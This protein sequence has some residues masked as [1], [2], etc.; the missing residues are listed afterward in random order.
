M[1]VA[2]ID[3][4]TNSMRLLVLAEDG[5]EI[6]RRVEVTGL[7]TGVDAT[8]HFAEDRLRDTL[9]VMGEFGDAIRHLGAHNVAA[10][11]TSATRDA[12]NGA[13]LTGEVAELIGIVPEVIS[14]ER[15]AVLSFAGAT[16]GRQSG[17]YIVID[18][19]GGSTEFIL[20]SIGGESRTIESAVS[21]DLGSV[22]LT[23][24]LITD[25]PVPAG[26]VKAAADH[27]LA[28][29]NGVPVAGS[30]EVIG[31]AGTF[32]SLAA[33]VQHLPEYNRSRVD[34]YALSGRDIQSAVTTLAAMTIAETEAIPSLD[35]KRAPVILAGSIIAGAALGA[36]G[37]D[38]ATVSEADL[39]TGLA[40]EL[41]GRGPAR[42][43]SN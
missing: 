39:L 41:L 33:I 30:A 19:G 1:T 13:E 9:G 32:T 4:G 7:G 3:I 31:V 2:A 40:Y 5:T 16:R 8:G 27:A 22:R 21:I 38:V 6:L 28:A 37:A 15:E 36:V 25:R 42:G 10:V 17:R 24:R 12:V 23:D 43:S 34:G 29:F 18:I 35:P 20:G 14:G 26:T 11:A